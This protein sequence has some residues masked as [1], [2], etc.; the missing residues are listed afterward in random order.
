MKE[1][2]FVGRLLFGGFLL[3]SSAHHFTQVSAMRYAT[4]QHGV[5][6]P[7]AAVLGAGV[8]LAIAAVSFLTGIAPR[9]GVA[10]LVLFLVPVTLTMHQFWREAGMTRVLDLI[11]FAKNVGL[12]G[13]GLM[14]LA[15]P[16]P[17]PYSLHLA[18]YLRRHVRA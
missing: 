16:E 12:L 8:L 6:F 5:P 9:V 3:F 1:L 11:N 14:V 18:G 13:G 2:S 7:T 17:W 4:A 15:I 10:A